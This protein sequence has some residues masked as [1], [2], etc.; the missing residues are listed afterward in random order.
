MEQADR[1][2]EQD[3][4][5]QEA[6]GGVSAVFADS[7]KDRF[8]RLLAIRTAAQEIIDAVNYALDSRAKQ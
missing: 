6:I 1:E 2:S 7:S 8:F 5:I 4:V 3:E